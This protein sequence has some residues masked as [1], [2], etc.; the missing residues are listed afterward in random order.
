MK[1]R[2]QQQFLDDN[3][4]VDGC[5]DGDA[6]FVV[7]EDE[8]DVTAYNDDEIEV[9]LASGFEM[10]NPEEAETPAPQE[11][12]TTVGQTVSDENVTADAGQDADEVDANPQASACVDAETTADASPEE[13]VVPVKEAAVS[14]ATTTT[15]AAAAAAAAD[16]ADK[17]RK[18]KASESSESRGKVMQ[19][20]IPNTPNL[21]VVKRTR[22][23]RILSST[24]RELERIKL[25]REALKK[26]KEAYGKVYTQVKTG[27]VPIAMPRSVK[28]LTQVRG[29]RVVSTLGRGAS[30]IE[31]SIFVSVMRGGHGEG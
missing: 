1:A 12:L 22:S 28:P 26:Q 20:T 10:V 27:N 23:E 16:K 31:F 5:D 8:E 29:D 11:I 3:E 13:A 25:E 14:T 15:T 24:S 7:S 17:L 30:G 4:E 2:A 6:S 9:N 21:R 18:R 19:L